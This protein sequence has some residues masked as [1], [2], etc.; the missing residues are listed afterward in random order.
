MPPTRVKGYHERRPGRHWS[1]VS[2]RLAL[3]FWECRAVHDDD[4]RGTANGGGAVPASAAMTLLLQVN[5]VS[6]KQ[7]VEKLE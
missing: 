6:Q 2:K 4:I 1:Q 5:T 7:S 3:I